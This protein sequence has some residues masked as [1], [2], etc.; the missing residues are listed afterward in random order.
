MFLLEYF[1]DAARCQWLKVA[2]MVWVEDGS[3]L[4]ALGVLMLWSSQH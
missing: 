3:N 4:R 1:S 2:V